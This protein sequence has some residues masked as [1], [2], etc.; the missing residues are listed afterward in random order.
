MSVR[1]GQSGLMGGLLAWPAVAAV[2]VGGVGYWPTRHLAGGPG[3]EAMGVALGLVTGAVYATMLPA[4]RRMA[5]ATTPATRF[6]AAFRAGLERFV[7]TLALAGAVAWRAGLEMRSF[8]LW[9]AIGYVLM[10]KVE[11]LILI[12]WSRRFEKR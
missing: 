7:I 9:V 2:V 12:R 5:A 6:K 11:T 10:I 4:M 3:I 1:A 8:L